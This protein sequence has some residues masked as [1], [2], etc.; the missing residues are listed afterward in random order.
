LGCPRRRENEAGID[1]LI[2]STA[3]VEGALRKTPPSVPM[4]ICPSL[5][6]ASVRT[7]VLGPLKPVLRA[8]HV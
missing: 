1:G 7:T 5:L 8:F 4:K 3:V 2:S 6:K